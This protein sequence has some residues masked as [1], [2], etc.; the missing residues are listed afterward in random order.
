MAV[1]PAIALSRLTSATRRCGKLR[2]VRSGGL[3]GMRG[4]EKKGL[5]RSVKRRDS[6]RR[7]S[8]FCARESSY[9]DRARSDEDI[10][11]SFVAAR[12]V[13]D[14]HRAARRRSPLPHCR[15]LGLFLC[16]LPYACAHEA[17][18]C[19]CFVV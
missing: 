11:R 4:E 12:V 6:A 1:C 14:S 3:E 13:L 9:T 10:S 7:P 8:Y 5:G 19:V 17:C 15:S 16:S 18:V 2:A